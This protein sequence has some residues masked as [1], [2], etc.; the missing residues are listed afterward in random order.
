MTKLKFTRG[1]KEVQAKTVKSSRYTR[2]CENCTFY[3]KTEEDEEEV[4]QNT[5]VLPYDVCVEESRTY[6]S[7]WKYVTNKDDA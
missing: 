3:L 7:F 6:C 5:N 2:S 1:Y 4:C